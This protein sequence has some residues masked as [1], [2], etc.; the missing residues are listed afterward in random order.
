M[1]IT[2]IPAQATRLLGAGL[3]TVLSLG[4]LSSGAHA[5]SQLNTRYPELAKLFN[6][7]DATQATLFEELVAI[8]NDP[9]T[10][11]ARNQLELHLVE[12]AAPMDHSMGHG[13][14]TMS[15]DMSGPGP[16]DQQE[17][18]ART[19]LIGVLRGDHTTEAASSAFENSAALERHTAI[20]I[21]R[22]RQFEA[23]LYEIYLDNSVTDKVASV[24]AAV[25][26][27]LSDARHSVPTT[28]KEYD[29]MAKNPHANAF[30]M[31]FPKLSG[32]LWANQWL[33]LAALEAIMIELN[34]PQFRN[35]MPEVLERFWNKIGSESGMTMFP[36]PSDLPMAATI[37]P[38]LYSFHPQAAIIIDNLNMLE[39]VVADA[40]SYPN[41]DDRQP[42]IDAAVAEYTNKESNISP[43]YDYLLAA[44]RG[45]IYNQGGP[46]VGDLGQSERNR[47]RG[48]MGMQHNM[49]M[50]QPI[51]Q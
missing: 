3:A 5:Q 4:M 1:P 25:A 30:I 7:F 10:R 11:L 51:P 32:M 39:T 50:S 35:T 34:D 33:Q 24:D 31:G 42:A 27:Y 8:N 49:N 45:G 26:D 20:V 21:Q 17:T 41:L 16:Y 12:M 19:R 28:P 23:R 47:S 38:H 44:L 15:M 9:A 29:L 2:S 18:A 48:E 43:D 36:P 37:A 14:H 13:G 40:L 22:G 6:A 46:A